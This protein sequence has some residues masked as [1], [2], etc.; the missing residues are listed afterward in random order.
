[1]CRLHVANILNSVHWRWPQSTADELQ[2]VCVLGSP[3]THQQVLRTGYVLT[4][5]LH[6]HGSSEMGQ[7]ALHV[8]WRLCCITG[9][10]VLQLLMKPAQVEVIA[11]GAFGW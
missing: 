10:D 4:N 7:R 3:T 2:Q 9:L 1:M 6:N 8:G 5:V 11:S